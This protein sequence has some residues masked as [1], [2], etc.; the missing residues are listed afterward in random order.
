VIPVARKVWQLIS[1]LMP[2]SPARRR[3]IRHMSD[4]T[5]GLPVNSPV[6]PLVVRNSGPLRSWPMPAA[7]YSSR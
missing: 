4:W 2:A 1:V 7:M 3:I 5:R 6:R